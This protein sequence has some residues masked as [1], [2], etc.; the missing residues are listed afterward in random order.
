MATYEELKQQA[1]AAFRAGD[2]EQAQVLAAEANALGN[3]ET[4]A[5]GATPEPADR[6]LDPTSDAPRAEDVDLNPGSYEELK[7]QALAAYRAGDEQAARDLAAQANAVKEAD[8]TN[9]FADIGRGAG[10]GVVNIVQGLTELGA[11]GIDTAFDTNTL[12]AV[13]RE[14]EEFKENLGFVPTGTAGKIAEGLVT[15][16]SAAIPI[17]GWLGRASTVAK[18][19][20]VLAGTSRWARSAEAFGRGPGKVLLNNR[21]KLAGSTALATGAADVL[22]AP[23][24]DET[25]SDQFDVLPEILRTED[26]EGMTGRQRAAAALRNKFRIGVEGG[27]VG[28][29][30]DASMPVIGATARGLSRAPG[31]PTVARALSRSMDY[32]GE[33]L[34]QSVFLRKNFTTA[35][36]L[37]KEIKENILSQEGLVDTASANA[38]RLFKNWDKS[39]RKAMGRQGLFTRNRKG[40][41]AAHSDLYD[42]MIGQMDEGEYVRRYGE[43]ARKA[44]SEMR[45]QVDGMTDMLAQQLDETDLDP[46]VKLQLL[47]ELEENKGRYLR[48]LYDVHLNPAKYEMSKIVSSPKYKDAVREVSENLQKQDPS[49]VGD[50]LSAEASR[51]IAEAINRQSSSL[52]IPIEAATNRVGAAVAREA[53]KA[54]RGEAPLFRIA[55]GMLKS[56]N[57]YLSASPALRDLM[58]EIKDPRA[59]YFKTVDQMANTVAANKFYRSIP[60][61]DLNTARQSWQNG[62]RPLAISGDQ[63]T[64]PGAEKELNDLGYV[65]L[66]AQGQA[67]E[68]D[69]KGQVIGSVFGGG[70]GDLSGAFVPV[71]M[72][73]ALTIPVRNATAAQE[74]LAL[75]LQ[76][77]GLSQ[78]SKTVLNP[79]SQ[80]RNALSNNFVLLA[81]GNWGRDMDAS[82]AWRL[83]AANTADMSD[84]AFEKEFNMLRL[85]DTIGQN[86]V[87][88]ETK[89]LL[90]EGSELPIARQTAELAQ[91]MAEK[92][93]IV[94]AAQRLYAAGDDFFKIIGHRAEKAKYTAALRRGKLTEESLELIAPELRAAGILPRTSELTGEVDLIDLLSTDIVKSTMPTYSRVPEAI[95]NLRRIPVVGNF[96]AFPAE[97]MRTSTNILDRA[98]KEMSFKP[99][100]ELIRKMGPEN[101]ERMAREIRA[102]GAQRAAGLASASFALPT[103]VVK[104]AHSALGVTEEQELAL[105]RVDAPWETGAQKMFVSAPK[106]G[107]AEYINLSYMMPYDFLSAPARAAM[108]IYAQKGETNTSDVKAIKDMVK[109]SLGKFLEPF[110]SESMAAERIADVTYRNG[111]TATGS[112]VYRDVEDDGTKIQKSIN[113]V[114]G[115]FLPGLVEQ[116]TTVSGGRFVQG[117][118]SRSISG[119]VGKQGQEYTPAEEAATMLT[120]FRRMALDLNNTFSYR[121]QEYNALRRQADGIFSNAVGA[122]DSTRE[123][124][125]NAYQESQQLRRRIQ[126]QMFADVQAARALGVSDERIATQ[127]MKD[128]G[129][130]RQEVAL[131]MD[132]RFA[133]RK[134]TRTMAEKVI[135]EAQV[136]DQARVLQS[137]PLAEINEIYGS[138]VGQPLEQGLEDE[139]AAQEEM[140]AEARAAYRSGDV[141]R[142]REL[143]AQLRSP[144]ASAPRAA[145]PTVPVVGSPETRQAPAPELLGGNLFDRMR[146]MEILNRQQEE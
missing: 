99:S 108:E 92:T 91:N 145:P 13:T 55:E 16:G 142:A 120:G 29:G 119:L 49:L 130:G 15:Y 10:A 83:L 77:K 134:P 7:Q 110:A 96:I 61:S 87:T 124:I 84:A 71:E 141:Q 125:V 113:H 5:V 132:G 121:G 98:L 74:A 24:T 39:V 112:I 63:I 75:S 104:A 8:E 45:Q 137:L 68:L 106:N 139:A 43:E 37:D 17:V 101:A 129:L 105:N 111:R 109:V 18:G 56:R 41:Q 131:I 6:N 143:A 140:R 76:A 52:G 116:F 126:S 57:P 65:R 66:G 107:Q 122:N 82:E 70:Y 33:K 31:A 123:D 26:L 22:V 127:L 9:T 86:L 117:R 32:A 85:T 97:I 47:G 64:T 1:L 21:A 54:S 50:E 103:A 89:A 79:L 88:N 38:A 25:I 81:N 138:S 35:G 11:L 36:L 51:I 60:V 40:I 136:Q 62:G 93:K 28:L 48:R 19:G 133:P 53:K 14:M 27:A 3:P 23:S 90:Q 144:V 135:R 4:S 78:M 2:V 69:D 12:S 34:G 30:V 100:R 42:F 73:R 94:P 114:I 102:I 80:I 58:G 115:G 118:T 20:K 46:A 95:K 146:N 128:V 44:A 67:A 59:L 72:Q